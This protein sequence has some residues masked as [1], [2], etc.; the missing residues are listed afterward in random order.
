MLHA[1]CTRHIKQKQPKNDLFR[2]A[3]ICHACNSQQQPQTQTSL[4][5]KQIG[6]LLHKVLTNHSNLVAYA[7]FIQHCSQTDKQL[8]GTIATTNFVYTNNSH[9]ALSPKWNEPCLLGQM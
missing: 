1:K 6:N 3:S 9:S 5:Y 8:D 2:A 7:S 4:K